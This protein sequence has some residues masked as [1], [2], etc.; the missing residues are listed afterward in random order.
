MNRYYWS[1]RNEA[2][3][4]KSKAA[5]FIRGQ[6][7]EGIEYRAKECDVVRTVSEIISGCDE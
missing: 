4:V 3:V 2:R 5:E 7:V 6:V 1:I